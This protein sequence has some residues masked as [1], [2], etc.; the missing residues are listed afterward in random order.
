[1]RISVLT[2]I[3]SCKN[4]NGR[5]EQSYIGMQ[6]VLNISKKLKKLIKKHRKSCQHFCIY[7]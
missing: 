2:T 4:E 3:Y 7:E 1:M 6:I 5:T